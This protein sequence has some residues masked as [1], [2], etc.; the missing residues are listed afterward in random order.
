MWMCLR[1]DCQAIGKSGDLC[2]R[3][4]TTDCRVRPCR[5]LSDVVSQKF[6]IK[7]KKKT[8]LVSGQQT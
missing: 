8:I 1:S 2:E 7:T 3:T 5:S 4:S 6:A